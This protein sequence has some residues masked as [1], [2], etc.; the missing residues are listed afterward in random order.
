MRFNPAFLTTTAF[1]TK[2]SGT[3]SLIVSSPIGYIRS[4]TSRL[5]SSSSSTISATT[6]NSCTSQCQCYIHHLRR[7]SSSR[8]GF[9][10]PLLRSEQQ[11]QQ[12]Q[13]SFVSSTTIHSHYNTNQTYCSLPINTSH[14]K[15]TSTNSEPNPSSS[16]SSSSLTRRMTTTTT[17]GTPTDNSGNDQPKVS[18][19]DMMNA[20]IQYKQ[21]EQHISNP[22]LVGQNIAMCMESFIRAD[23]VCFDV[24]STVIQEEG[25]DVLADYLGKGTAVANLTKQ[26]MEG[27][28]KF[29]DALEARLSLLQPSKLQIESCLRDHP[30]QLTKGIKELI[31]LL[32]QYHKDVFFISGG[33]RIM[34]EPIARELQ[35][36]PIK[37][38]IANQLLFDFDL[39]YNGFDTNEYTSQDMGKPKAIQHI[40]DTHPQYQTIVMVGDGMTDAQTK[41]PASSF[42][43]FGG[44]VVREKVQQNADWFISDF[45]D[46]IYLLN[47]YGNTATKL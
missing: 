15:M 14:C 13:R 36:D 46:L 31:Q 24:D 26:A 40:L 16:K 44:V 33:F 11:Q 5:I 2:R 32:Q 43:G 39:F 29:Q 42:I 3:T 9:S 7:R 45:D 35:I 10:I 23:C 27:G 1:T 47:T 19:N 34:I 30:F 41:P 4:T 20:L 6:G 17:K 21:D 37:N 12:Q 18:G 28:M 38:V 22:I 25:I 8:S